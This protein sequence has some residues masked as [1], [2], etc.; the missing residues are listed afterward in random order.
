MHVPAY[1]YR[2]VSFSEGKIAQNPTYPFRRGLR[3]ST[4]E[5]LGRRGVAL[6][7]QVCDCLEGGP[8]HELYGIVGRR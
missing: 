3:A 6:A 2:Y 5:G 1:G 8:R 7:Q 4:V